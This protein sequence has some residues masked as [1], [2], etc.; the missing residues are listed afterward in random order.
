[1]SAENAGIS[2]KWN[3]ATSQPNSGVSVNY[4]G[5][6]KSSLWEVL[7]VDLVICLEEKKRRTE[8]GIYTVFMANTL[9]GWPGI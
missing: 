6:E 3:V 5:E 2:R 9:V 1:M 7:L 8:T 4:I